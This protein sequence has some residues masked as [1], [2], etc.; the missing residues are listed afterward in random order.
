MIFLL[1]DNYL[2]STE[3]QKVYY[4]CIISY[5]EIIYNIYFVLPR[6][7]TVKSKIAHGEYLKNKEPLDYFRCVWGNRY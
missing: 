3:R 5:L 2:K 6:E 7:I 1:N 4:K